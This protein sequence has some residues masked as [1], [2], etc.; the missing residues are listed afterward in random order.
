MR[1][2]IKFKVLTVLL[3]IVFCSLLHSQETIIDSVYSDMYLDGHITYWRISD[4]YEVDTTYY[5]I[6][7]G[8]TGDGPLPP[9]W[10]EPNSVFRAYISFDLPQI[11]EGYHIDSVY[12]RL[13][14]YFGIGN[15]GSLPQL[16]FPE[17]NIAGGDTVKCIMSH[18]DYG[19]E[20]D[21]GDWEKGDIGN[22]YTFQ[23]NIGTI[24]ESGDVGY[25]YLDLT[26]SV[27]QDYELERDKTQYR[28]S[29]QIDTDWDELFDFI[30]ISTSITF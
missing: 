2:V 14:Q 24:T 6:S 1:K 9:P 12:V 21:A 8:D 30:G 29:F 13:Y 22:P 27:L 15:G 26:S 4:Y 7:I 11:P 16:D 23:N 3:L 19:D 25:R 28:I 18:I 5:S 10:D 17:W 20:L